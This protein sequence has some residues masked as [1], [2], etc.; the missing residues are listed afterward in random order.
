MPSYGQRSSSNLLTAHQDLRTIFNYVILTYD[1]SVIYGIRTQA[2]QFELYKKGRKLAGDAWVIADMKKVVTWKDGTLKRSKHQP[3]VGKHLSMA[4][5]VIPYHKDYPHI[6]WQDYEGLYNFGGY[7]MGIANMLKRYGDIEHDL[8]WGGDW[9]RDW[10]LDDQTF[11]D[12][13]HFQLV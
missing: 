10:D 8:V 2:E 12:L 6:R 1:N 3:A 7:V 5:D 9:D 4:V 11:M 13:V